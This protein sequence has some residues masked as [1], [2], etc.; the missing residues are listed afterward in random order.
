MLAN[1]SYS[2]GSVLNTSAPISP[3]AACVDTIDGGGCSDEARR[4]WSLSFRVVSFGFRVEGGAGSQECEASR[5]GLEECDVER[6][7]DARGI[8]QLE[9]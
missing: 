7:A 5:L 2:A 9:H 6:T 4:V 1:K 3:R 8:S